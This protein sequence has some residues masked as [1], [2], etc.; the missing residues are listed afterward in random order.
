[1]TAGALA[2]LVGT[3]QWIV[4]RAEIAQGEAVGLTRG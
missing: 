4:E 1:M 3:E 2:R